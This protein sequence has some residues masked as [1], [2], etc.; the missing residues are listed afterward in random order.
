MLRFVHF[1]FECSTEKVDII[2]KS[3]STYRLFNHLRPDDFDR[4]GK[5]PSDDELQIYTWF[6]HFI[7]KEEFLHELKRPSWF[8]LQTEEISYHALF[9]NV[10]VNC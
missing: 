8:F 6:V 5:E 1:L 2:G 3:L 7:Q 4:R 9:R 10:P